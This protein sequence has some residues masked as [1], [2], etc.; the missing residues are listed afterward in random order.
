[1]TERERERPINPK[2]NLIHS[3]ICGSARS[4]ALSSPPLYNMR[5]RAR[6]QRLPF[7]LSF[8]RSLVH[9]RALMVAMSSLSCEFS[10]VCI[11]HLVKAD[12]GLST[13]GDEVAEWMVTC[14]LLAPPGEVMGLWPLF[15]GVLPARLALEVVFTVWGRSAFTTA[16]L[17]GF[18]SSTSFWAPPRP[19]WRTSGGPPRSSW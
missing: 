17:E 15:W 3:F 8:V 11:L 6:L 9:L 2:G 12:L 4:R 7:L 10:H 14:L 13:A 16:N 1:M 18:H 5:L 19:P